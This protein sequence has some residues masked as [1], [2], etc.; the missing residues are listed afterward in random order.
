MKWEYDTDEDN[1]VEIFDHNGE[2]VTI[3][4]NANSPQLVK[5]NGVPVQPDVKGAIV[6]YITTQIDS[7]DFP[8]D[9]ALMTYIQTTQTIL[10]ANK[11]EE[12][13]S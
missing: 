6:D 4:E 3:A 13:E 11:I 9:E 5:K 8:N 12:R 7:S 2:Q 10:S 1:N